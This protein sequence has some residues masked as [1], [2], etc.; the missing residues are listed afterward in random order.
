MTRLV[1]LAQGLRGGLVAAIHGL[2]VDADD[3]PAPIDHGD[4]VPLDVKDDGV[5]GAARLRRGGPLR[6]PDDARR[7][8]EAAH[9]ERRRHRLHDV[10]NAAVREAL[11]G[12]A[13][14]FA[15]A[16]AGDVG[17]YV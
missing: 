10:V 9:R 8:H 17:S 6:A 11:S 16:D 2:A 4:E 14:R 15:D 12:V 1:D 7:H 13:L 3:A 5:D